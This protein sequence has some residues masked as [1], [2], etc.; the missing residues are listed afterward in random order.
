MYCISADGLPHVHMVIEDTKAMRFSAIKKTYAI[1]AH[2]EP[3]KGSKQQAEAY[4]SKQP[5]YDEKGEIVLCC[6]RHGEIKGAPGKRTDI[7]EIEDMIALGISANEILRTSF[8]YRRY[9]RMIRAACL[10]RRYAE[11]PVFRSLEVHYIFGS[12]GAGKSYLFA[13][14]C[15]THGED[16]VYHMSDF[17]VGGFDKYAGE[18]ILFLDEYKGE[19]SYSMFLSVTDRYKTQVHARFSN[20]YMLW[21]QVYITSIYPP[22]DLYALMV[23]ADRRKIDTYEQLRRRINDITY[24]FI[25][26]DGSRKRYTLPMDAYRSYKEFVNRAEEAISFPD[27]YDATTQLCVTFTNEVGG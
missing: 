8:R 22:E 11:T 18:P 12:S 24:C 21:S 26:I 10:D 6:I 5:P 14:L 7:D 25:D 2:L 4:I 19:W 13:E 15:K 9:E 16:N 17:L 23:P 3:T 1:G 20:V 27:G